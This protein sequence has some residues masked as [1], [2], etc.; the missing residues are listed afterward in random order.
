M[1]PVVSGIPQGSPISPILATF[2]S[3]E[4]IK[5]FAQRELEHRR[6]VAIVQGLDPDNE[7]DMQRAFDRG[8]IATAVAL[9]M[10]V[11]YGKI[12]VSSDSLERNV[13]LLMDAYKIVEEWLAEVGLAS[14]LDKRELM[15]FTRRHK[16]DKD[17]NPPMTIVDR[18]GFTR[19][20]VARACA[21]WLGI[22]LDRKLLFNDH[23]KIMAAKAG[24]AVGRLTMLSNTIRGLSQADISTLYKA[25]VIPI[26]TYA[27]PAWWTG[28]GKHETT[29]A[30]IQHRA[31]RLTCAA[32]RT[33]PVHALEV[34]ASIPPLR[35]ILDQEV[36]RY[37]VRLNKLS[38]RS[39]VINR[40]PNS[41]R[42]GN[43]P[44]V[45]P[46]LPAKKRRRRAT[47]KDT[48]PILEAAKHTKAEHE[49]L[50]PSAAPP[51]R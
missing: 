4:L 12:Y 35:H 11:D 40:L 25:R 32:F 15:H 7:D 51:W 8:D 17:T 42:S 36:R 10:Y 18:D 30:M 13:Q 29:M 9:L 38:T 33:S 3:A 24:G 43:A 39:P 5:T 19:T 50:E 16:K 28:K 2:Y 22:H 37:G 27:A 46:R 48:T 23:V 31:L 1:K 44:H 20:V 47:T 45:L 34:E 26:I 6:R 41:W 14:D 49:C 21:R